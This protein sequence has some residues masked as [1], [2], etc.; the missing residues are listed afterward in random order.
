LRDVQT[1]INT[2]RV[3]PLPAY[4]HGDI[5]DPNGYEDTIGGSL[6]HVSFMLRHYSIASHSIFSCELVELNVLSRSSPGI[7]RDAGTK[8]SSPMK[9]LRLYVLSIIT[10][11]LDL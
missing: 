7:K 2:H 3:V 6:V 1:I 10:L 8:S 5:I 9:K 11:A 4:E